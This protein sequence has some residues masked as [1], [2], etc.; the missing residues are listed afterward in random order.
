MRLIL[1]ALVFFPLSG[2]G[3]STRGER[4]ELVWNPYYRLQESD[5]RGIPDVD[6][7][8]DAGASV[9]ITAKPF[10]SGKRIEYDV[11]AIFDRQRSW[12]RGMSTSLLEHEQ[13]HFDIA[14]LYARKIR[15]R[16][17]ELQQQRVRDIAVYNREIQKLLK[18][19]NAYDQRYDIETLHGAMSGKQEI[20]TE[21][22]RAELASLDE[23][24][25]VKR[26]IGLTPH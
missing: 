6:S 14:E 22:V 23:Y 19:S 3:Q 15:E 5:F 16:I 12:A 2:N 7:P 1:L 18:E 20:W 26:T 13:L 8:S 10:V 9:K 11:R 24:R 17:H 21:R 25:E 4:N